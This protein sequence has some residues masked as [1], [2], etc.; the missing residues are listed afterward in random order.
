MKVFVREPALGAV[1]LAMLLLMAVFIV[2]PQVQ[3]VIVPGLAGYVAF[4]TEGPN[5]LNA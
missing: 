1:T 4:F 5:W 2:L 3:V